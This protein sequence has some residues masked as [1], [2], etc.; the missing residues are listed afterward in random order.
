MASPNRDL[1]LRV[2]ARLEPLLGEM[3]FVGGHVAELLITDPAATRVRAT[4]DV[5]VVC[6]A[7]SRSEYQELGDQLKAHGF[8]EDMRDGAPTCRWRC[9]NDILD[10]MPAEGTVLGFR[11]RWHQEVLRTAQQFQLS[12][13]LVIPIAAGPAFLATKADAFSDRGEGDLYGSHDIEDIIAVVAGRPTILS[14][15]SS[16]APDLREYLSRAAAG[17]LRS[18]S[19]EDVVLGALPDARVLPGTTD[20]VM[21]RF[22]RMSQL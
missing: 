1:L 7:T 21:K 9:G 10:V 20:I 12:D 4:Q 3:V 18:E 6:S 2:S 11:G 17:F 22:R 5:D 19:F 15:V 8:T 16:S 14:E 13:E